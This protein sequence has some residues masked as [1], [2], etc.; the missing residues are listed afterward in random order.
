M[1]PAVTGF[2]FL[3]HLHIAFPLP[4]TLS[5]SADFR[6]RGAGRTGRKRADKITNWRVAQRLVTKSPR[7]Q[8]GQRTHTPAGREA[9]TGKPRPSRRAD[10]AKT[11]TSSQNP[12]LSCDHGHGPR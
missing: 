2:L 3:R 5:L 12:A 10:A 7:R 11:T 1:L 4:S 8:A 6:I 9:H